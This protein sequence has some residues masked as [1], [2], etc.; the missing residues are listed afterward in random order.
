MDYH[1][2]N[3]SLCLKVQNKLRCVIKRIILV[4]TKPLLQSSCFQQVK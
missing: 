4:Y 3:Q 1:K 2:I